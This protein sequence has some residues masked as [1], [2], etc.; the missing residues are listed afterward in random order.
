ME[1]KPV[2][3]DSNLEQKI[4]W[5]TVDNFLRNHTKFI[6]KSPASPHLNLILHRNKGFIHSCG[7][8][9]IVMW[10]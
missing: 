10:G 9:W 5:I 4:L 1:K 3:P 6:E 7:N 2:S 8:R